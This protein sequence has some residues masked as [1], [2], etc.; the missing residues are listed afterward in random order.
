M[1]DQTLNEVE[2][3]EPHQKAS[4]KQPAGPPKVPAMGRSPQ[5]DQSDH[6]EH[7]GH[8]MEEAVQKRVELEVLDRISGIPGTRGDVMPLQDLMKHDPVE[9]AAQAQPEEDTGRQGK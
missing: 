7:V 2:E 9:E 5:D 8:G 4:Q 3:A 1:I 6:D